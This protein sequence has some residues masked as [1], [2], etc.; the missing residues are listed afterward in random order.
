MFATF[1]DHILIHLQK[2]NI[3]ALPKKRDTHKQTIKIKKMTLPKVNINLG[4]GNLGQVAGTSDGVAGLILTGKAV[5][6]KLELNKHYQIGNTRDL[7]T[8]GIDPAT[9][10]LADKEVKA[11]YAQA[12]EGAELHLLI[13]SEA[14]T[15]TAMCDTAADAPLRQLIDAAGGRIR[16]VG[17]NKLPAEEFEAEITQGID[18]DAITAAEKAQ[19]T[20][21]SYAAQIRPFRMLLP[22]PDWKGTTE[23]LYKPSEASHNRVGLILASDD[24][25][26]KTAAVGMVLGRAARM[27]VQQSIG[28]VKSGAIATN[29][30]FTS[31]DNF[32]AKSGMAESLDEAGYIFFINYPTKNGC[33][34]NGDHMAA[35][36]SDDYSSLSLGRV[37][38]KAMVI[39]Y[40]T[41]IS[42]ILDN[43]R[44]DEKGGLPV[45]ICKNFEGMIENAVNTSMGT[46]IS[47]FTAYV[48]PA[49][50][51]LSSGKLTI[52]CKLVP[53]GL[54]HEIQVNLAF[55]NPAL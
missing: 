39:A 50:N 44:V 16:L 17:A 5:A 32:L 9:N 47:N 26:S 3:P 19:Q 4:N 21:E 28:R 22:A 42:E 8:L 34:L 1:Q 52:D 53:L 14:T 54:L 18:G 23:N 45:G 10:F 51:I 41:Y 40:T 31:G 29:G 38:D 36:A 49:Q 11:F 33:Y 30:F 7:K 46:Q 24:A 6:G 15:L 37:I 13:V 20:A 2:R 35:P 48:D 43:I 55:D 12:G 27:E 25:A